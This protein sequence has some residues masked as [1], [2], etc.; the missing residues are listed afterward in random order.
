MVGHSVR[1]NMVFRYRRNARAGRRF[2]RIGLRT[3]SHPLAP[4]ESAGRHQ[5]DVVPGHSS[6]HAGCRHLDIVVDFAESSTFGK[7][8]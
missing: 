3:G 7:V 8:E 5:L 6:N 4:V 2:S 1:S